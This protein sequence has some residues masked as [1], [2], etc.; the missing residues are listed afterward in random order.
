[1]MSG[2]STMSV[3][4]EGD[5][6]AIEIKV[7]TTDSSTIAAE[8][9]AHEDRI[10]RILDQTIRLLT[11]SVD[12]ESLAV[13]F[14]FRRVLASHVNNTFCILA[15]LQDLGVR[16]ETALTHEAGEVLFTV[17]PTESKGSLG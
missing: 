4:F 7:Q 10:Q 8:F 12:N 16:A 2:F 1:M 17:T 11:S 6:L 3:V 13:F 15:V 14:N 9:F 5:E